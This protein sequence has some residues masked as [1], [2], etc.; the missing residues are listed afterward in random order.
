MRQSTT[1]DPCKHKITNASLSY[2]LI[3]FSYAK[4]KIT[5]RVCLDKTTV[6]IYKLV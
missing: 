2:C 4:S 5:A 6:K 3:P 1:I